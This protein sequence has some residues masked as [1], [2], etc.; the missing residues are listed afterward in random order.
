MCLSGYQPKDK[1]GIKKT[2]DC[3]VNCKQTL[4]K[5]KCYV[6]LCSIKNESFDNKVLKLQCNLSKFTYILIDN[7]I[8]VMHDVSCT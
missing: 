7:L 8:A 1:S 3:A 2:W 5:K 6:L 4:V